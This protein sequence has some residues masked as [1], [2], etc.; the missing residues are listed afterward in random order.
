MYIDPTGQAL[1]ELIYIITTS[2]KYTIKQCIINMTDAL[3]YRSNKGLTLEQAEH[4]ARF[5][6]AY[7]RLEGWSHNAICA[8][9][10]NMYVESSINPGLY[11]YSGSGYRTGDGSLSLKA[12]V[13]FTAKVRKKGGHLGLL[14]FL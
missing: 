4:N 2:I 11:Q 7:L 13:A 5:I 12:V 3:T 10:G 8:T 1:E 6:Y 14:L 9:L